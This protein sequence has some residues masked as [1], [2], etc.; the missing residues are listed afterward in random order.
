MAKTYPTIGPFT[1]GDILTAA[2][3]TDIQ[4]NLTN[5]RVPPMCR[6]NQTSGQT[7]NDATNTVLTFAGEQFD[8]DGMHDLVTNNSRITIQTAGVYLV[9]GSAN[10]TAG[11]SDDAAINILKNGS[12]GNGGYVAFGPANTTAGMTTTTLLSLAVS[13]YLELSVYQNNSANTPR[14]T[15]T[16]ATYLS[17]AWLGQA[18]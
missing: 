18:S 16:T 3:M 6:I 7:I 9:T 11:V 13:D 14:T 17:A 10:Y 8:T 2:T 12:G 5:Q 4:T 1:A 15:D